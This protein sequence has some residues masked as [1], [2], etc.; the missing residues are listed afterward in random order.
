[1]RNFGKCSM[2]T[3][4]GGIFPTIGAGVTISPGM[5]LPTGSVTGPSRELS[6]AW[7]FLTVAL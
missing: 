4:L 5:G 6:V 2:A 3:H 7:C 1:M